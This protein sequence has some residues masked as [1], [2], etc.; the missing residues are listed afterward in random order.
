MPITT[1]AYLAFWLIQL[2]KWYVTRPTSTNTDMNPADSA[3]LT[4]SARR[5]VARWVPGT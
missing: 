5:I 3:P 2:V 1:V 4:S